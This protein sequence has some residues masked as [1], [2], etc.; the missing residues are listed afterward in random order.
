MMF[1]HPILL[2]GQRVHRQGRQ[3]C[4]LPSL[5]MHYSPLPM[6]FSAF[7]HLAPC[8]QVRRDVGQGAVFTAL[9][10]WMVDATGD[11]SRKIVYNS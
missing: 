4:A 9:V 2:S 6:F 3:G 5:G 1:A 10:P 8:R 7:S 11:L